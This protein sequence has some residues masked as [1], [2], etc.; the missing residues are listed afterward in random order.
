MGRLSGSR[1]FSWPCFCLLPFFPGLSGR[2]LAQFAMVIA[3]T[4]LISAINAMTLKP[5]QC[6][7][8]LRPPVP[9]EQRNFFYRGFN[10]VYNRLENAYARLIGALVKRSG[11]VV[12]VGL[13]V[14]ALGIWGIARLPTAFIPIEDQGYGMI[15]VQ[16]PDGAA[17]G[18]TVNSL[19]ETTK[20]ALATPGV[21]QVITIAGI[22]VLDNSATL[23]TPVSITSSLM[24]GAN[25]A[26]QRDRNFKSLLFKVAE[27]DQALFRTDGRLSWYRR[28]SKEL[29]M[30]A[31]SR[32]RCRSSAAASIIPSSMK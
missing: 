23:A 20:I 11:L 25:A 13:I 3:A 2:M 27:Q 19:N 24:I 26:K 21:K 10:A 15:A 18:R 29:E 1:L 32:C 30:R 17:L 7:L 8:W 6:A 14:S 28:Q 16:L 12:L 4:A 9:P 31:V 22:S 5:T